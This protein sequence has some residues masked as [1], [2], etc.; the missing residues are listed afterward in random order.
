METFPAV[1]RALLR[2]NTG[3]PLITFYDLGTGE[4]VEQSV[5]TYANWVAKASSLLEE[6]GVERGGTV[7]LAL[8][9]H[10]LTPV[11]VG[12]AANLGA[13]LVPGPADLQVVGPDGLGD[14]DQAPTTL[15]CSLLPLGRPFTTPLPDGVVDVGVDVWSQPDSYVPWDPPGAGDPFA[16]GRDQGGTWRGAAE[17]GVVA[18]GGR[19]L[20]DR[21]PATDGLPLLAAVLVRGASLVLVTGAGDRDRIAV[22]EQVTDRS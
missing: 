21:N 22:Q 3:R 5:A 14:L 10:W 11:F 18:V 9:V 13:E 4:R 1:L 15:A 6:Y 8:P 19:L 20:T 12:A 2:G 7:R 17:N 16:D